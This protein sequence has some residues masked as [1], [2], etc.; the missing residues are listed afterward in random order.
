MG[1]TA[2]GV[3]ALIVEP[4]W[5]TWSGDRFVSPPCQHSTEQRRGLPFSRGETRLFESWLQHFSGSGLA[6]APGCLWTTVAM[7]VGDVIPALVAV[8]AGG[9][10]GADR[11]ALSPHCVLWG[12]SRVWGSR[13]PTGLSLQLPSSRSCR[14]SPERAVWLCPHSMYI[15]TTCCWVFNWGNISSLFSVSLNH[16]SCRCSSLTQTL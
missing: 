13:S 5:G 4:V 7:N 15:L 12:S 10:A 8:V 9:G 11:A 14:T 16:H 1:L 6:E 3:G 2:T